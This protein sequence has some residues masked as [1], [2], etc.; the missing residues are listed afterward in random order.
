MEHGGWVLLTGVN[1]STRCIFVRFSHKVG[2][3]TAFKANG[4]G[5]QMEDDAIQNSY[6]RS[7]REQRRLTVTC[8]QRQTKDGSTILNLESKSQDKQKCTC[9]WCSKTRRLAISLTSHVISWW[10]MPRAE[11]SVFGRDQMNKISLSSRI[12]KAKLKT[13]DKL[14]NCWHSRGQRAKTTEFIWLFRT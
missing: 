7:M 3:I 4:K 14:L 10:S 13:R 8:I 12:P 5:K 1:S 2:K 9:R 11:D 6:W